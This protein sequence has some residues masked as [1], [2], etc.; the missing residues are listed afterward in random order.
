MPKGEG[1]LPLGESPEVGAFGKHLPELDVVLLQLA[2]L[3][4]PAWLAVEE[5]GELPRRPGLE[6]DGEGV[7]E[8]RPVVGEDDPEGLGDE[9]VPEGLPYPGEGLRDLRG[10]LLGEEEGGHVVALP[11]ARRNASRNRRRYGP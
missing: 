9:A 2:F 5:P 10:S 1:E 3:A 6:L 7:E 4:G 11:G 8:L